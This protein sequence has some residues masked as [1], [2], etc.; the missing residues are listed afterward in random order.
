MEGSAK[1]VYFGV[2]VLG[3]PLGRWEE[4]SCRGLVSQKVGVG[5]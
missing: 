4:V 1:S 5:Q 2:N 3:S